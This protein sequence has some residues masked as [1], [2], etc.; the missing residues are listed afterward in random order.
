MEFFL[1]KAVGLVA[2]TL[3]SWYVGKRWTDFNSVSDIAVQFQN[4][5]A[6][7]EAEVQTIEARLVDLKKL[8]P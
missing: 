5:K 8:I 7:I 3:I 1:L 4:A 6:A 2:W